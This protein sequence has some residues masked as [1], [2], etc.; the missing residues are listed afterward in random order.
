MLVA[1]RESGGNRGRSVKTR[2]SYTE[3]PGTVERREVGT[4]NTG[5]AA[6][7]K[8]RVVEG[9]F[10][11][12]VESRTSRMW[13]QSLLVIRENRDQEIAFGIRDAEVSLKPRRGFGEDVLAWLGEV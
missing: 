12:P 2:P 11:T 3:S 5:G 6:R 10:Q 8:V 1:S 4:R 9:V 7:E 13:T